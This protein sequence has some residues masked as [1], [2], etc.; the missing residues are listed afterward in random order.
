[1]C[2][3]SDCSR[4]LNSL[5]VSP[6]SEARLYMESPPLSLKKGLLGNMAQ[7]HRCKNVE[8]IAFFLLYFSLIQSFG[9]R[10]RESHLVKLSVEGRSEDL[11]KSESR[12]SQDG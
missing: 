6:Q 3:I 1:M 8:E 2:A 4:R 10:T 11:L 9:E 7:S 5:G 12:E